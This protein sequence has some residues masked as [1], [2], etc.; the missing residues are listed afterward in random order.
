M[1]GEQSSARLASQTA[2]WG[3]GCHASGARPPA[4]PARPGGPPREW[5]AGSA[6]SQALS[7]DR[8]PGFQS[9]AW[10]A[11]GSRWA[12]SHQRGRPGSRAPLH[13]P[14]STRAGRPGST[15]SLE[16]FHVRE[17]P[18]SQMSPPRHRASGRILRSALAPWGPL[19]GQRHPDAR[20]TASVSPH[21]RSPGRYGPPLRLA[22][23]VGWWHA[24]RWQQT[25]RSPRQ[26]SPDGGQS[27]PHPRLHPRRR[28][29]H[30]RGPALQS[31]PRPLATL[32]FARSAPTPITD[33]LREPARS[34]TLVASTGDP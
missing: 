9:P 28:P 24:T 25:M 33:E 13:A 22:P 7:P 29:P 31:R 2:W 11:G 23:R 18:T 26:Q 34:W 17:Q 15:V 19:A 14:F 4:P 1:E 16:G 32:T 12:A 21:Q 30:V 27:P 20:L 5:G 3:R 10:P 8:P 6:A